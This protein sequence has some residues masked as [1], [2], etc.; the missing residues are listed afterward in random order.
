MMK[1][2]QIN[3]QKLFLGGLMA[4]LVISSFM[5]IPVNASDD[6]DDDGLPDEEEDEDNDGV[7]DHDEEEN[8][9]NLQIE[10]SDKEAHIESRLKTGDVHNEF[11]VEMHAE[12]EGLKFNFEFERDNDTVETE[13]EFEVVLTEIIEYRDI[14]ADGYYNESTDEVVQVYELDEFNP[15]VYTIETISNNTV[16]VFAIET[17]DTVF[18]ATIYIAGEFSLVNDVLVAPTQLKIDIGIHNFNYTEL[19]TVLALKV[20]LGSELE[21]DY[22]DDD[23]TEDEEDERAT[24]EH[25]VEISIGD[26]SGFFSWIETATVDG[27]VKEVK[28]TPIEIGEEENKLYL[29]YP[30]GNEIIHDP[31]IGIAGIL[32]TTPT[33]FLGI[34]PWIVLPDLSRNELLI[35]SAV[36]FIAITSLVMIFRRKK[37]A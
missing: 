23:V 15:I 14:A 6:E 18:S 3:R 27:V 16:H 37:R 20:K 10:V 34:R 33:G 19:D 32:Q 4:I 28:A 31:K 5:Y 29:N 26:Y 7:H 8:E 11:N 12:D 9:R 13:I 24:D 1:A 30:R 25:E 22:E 21:V 35:V 36:A 2:K 17:N